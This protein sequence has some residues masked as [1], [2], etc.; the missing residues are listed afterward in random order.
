[1]PMPAHSFET[2]VLQDLEKLIQKLS[3]DIQQQEDLL[4]PHAISLIRLYLSSLRQ[5]LDWRKKMS[6]LD[7]LQ[8]AHPASS[9]PAGP[10]QNRAGSLGLLLTNPSQSPFPLSHPAP[11]L[12]MHASEPAPG[13][14]L[15]T[16]L[17]PWPRGHEN[18]IPHKG[19]KPGSRM[20]HPPR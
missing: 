11:G 7:N 16:D 1:M 4:N 15:R 10:A 14:P 5:Y 2:D 19:G 9:L 20:P 3:H 17:S 8:P 12:L 13:A 6:M 18:N